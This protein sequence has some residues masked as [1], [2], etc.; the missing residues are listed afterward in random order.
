MSNKIKPPR[1][2]M[3]IAINCELSKYSRCLC[4]THY[5][6]VYALIQSSV[7]TEAELIAL[8]LLTKLN[9]PHKYTKS[10]S[11]ARKAVNLL[12]EGN[13]KRIPRWEGICRINDCKNKAGKKATRGT[14]TSCHQVL[15]RRVEFPTNF[16]KDV[17][18]KM[19]EDAQIIGTINKPVS[20]M[21]DTINK[22]R[23]EH[24]A[25]IKGEIK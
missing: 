4:I 19:L 12:L 11:A 15:T 17:T 22:A 7:T 10:T 20:T 3:C 8:H 5:N 23:R 14:C 21:L 2:D 6:E 13:Y 24:L 16:K 9:K 18:W 25:V 1:E